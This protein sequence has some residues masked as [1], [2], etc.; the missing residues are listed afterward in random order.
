[1]DA[2]QLKHLIL[3][4]GNINLDMFYENNPHSRPDIP[5]TLTKLETLILI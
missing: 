5:E 1:M 4:G 2:N 3:F